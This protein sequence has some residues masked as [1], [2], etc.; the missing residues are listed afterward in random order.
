MAMNVCKFNNGVG[1]CETENGEFNPD[2]S[3]CGWNPDVAKFRKAKLQVLLRERSEKTRAKRVKGINCQVEK[4]DY[5][6][7]I[8]T[9]RMTKDE[10]GSS[11]SL[12]DEGKGIML[13]IPLEAVSD[14]LK[15]VEKEK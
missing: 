4:F 1:C 11:L 2:C 6:P 7:T 13:M 5:T 9:V 15:I 12:L 14:M 10:V 8:I 3:K